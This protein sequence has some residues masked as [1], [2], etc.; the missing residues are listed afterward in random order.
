[1]STVNEAIAKHM[2]LG[3]ISSHYGFELVPPFAGGVTVTSLCDNADEVKPGALYVPEGRVDSDQFETAKRN[4]AYAALIA[5]DAFGEDGRKDGFDIPV[6]LAGPSAVQIGQL[7][8]DIAGAPAKILAI[9]AVCGPDP[10]EV[11]ADAV[12]VA[13]FLHVLGNPVGLL[14]ASGSLSL[15]RQLDLSYPLGIFDVQRAMA[16]CL[17]DS[18]SAM[19]I[20]ADERTLRHDAL[21]SVNVDVLGCAEKMDGRR[22][23]ETVAAARKT[24]GFSSEGTLHLTT[25]G[26][27]ASWMVAQSSSAEGMDSK[28]RLALAISMAIDAGVRRGNIRSALRVSQEMH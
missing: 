5:P 20:A 19:V 3:Y 24:Y 15:E 7:A 14:S 26:E 25:I 18:A 10:D 17:E 11:Q 13:D 2:T 22:S 6:L 23:R 28:R 21:Q 27:D 16:I 8:N 9:F 12:R 1:M 4:G